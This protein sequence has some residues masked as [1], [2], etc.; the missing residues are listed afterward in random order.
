[1]TVDSIQFT[2]L[3]HY[4]ARYLFEQNNYVAICAPRQ[5]GKT[6]FLRSI[7]DSN[8]SSSVLVLFPTFMMSAVFTGNFRNRS[9]VIVNVMPKD[10]V[11]LYRQSFL[12][13]FDIVLG[14]EV[15]LPRVD[16][17][18]IAC[19]FTI[20]PVSNILFNKK[21]EIVYWRNTKDIYP[22]VWKKIK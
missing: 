21:S 5:S 17:I 18:K 3:R 7:I 12:Y 11:S 1:M 2:S 6:S 8:P 22:F 4:R 14:D 10:P 20:Y 9:N 15:F 19:V 13:N 16:N